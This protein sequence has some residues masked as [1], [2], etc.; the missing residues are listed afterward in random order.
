MKTA[1]FGPGLFEFL[2]DLARHN[3]RAW[4]Q[5]NQRRYEA[6][7]KAPMLRFIEDFGAPLKRISAQFLA[8]PRPVGGALFR[9]HR[10]TRFST[11]KSPYK[12][13]AAAH[14]RHREGSR[15]VHAPGFYLHLEPSGSMEGA[16]CGI[17]TPRH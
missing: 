8:D 6:E 5:A 15:D 4:F 3:D 10:D 11:D 14:F 16:A 12:T 9:I 7:V 1:H 13:N 2:R 17:P